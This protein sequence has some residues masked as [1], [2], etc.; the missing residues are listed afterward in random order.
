MKKLIS[1]LLSI[2]MLLSIFS[3]TGYAIDE[4]FASGVVYADDIAP[5][6]WEL[7]EDGGTLYINGKGELID[8]YEDLPWRSLNFKTLVI[9]E[10]VTL[11]GEEMFLYATTLETVILPSSFLVILDRAFY[12]CENLKEIEFPDGLSFIGSMA[13]YG[14]ISLKYIKD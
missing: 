4:P 2:V 11:I 13:F 14:C 8:V 3:V 5:F 6:T 9:G 1:F 12:G 7:D 10:G